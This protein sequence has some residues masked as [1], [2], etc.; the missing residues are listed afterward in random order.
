MN[1]G[2]DAPREA[3]VQGRTA[4]PTMGGRRGLEVRCD[5]LEACRWLQMLEP[6][7]RLRR[8]TT[9]NLNAKTA[10]TAKGGILP[11]G[12]QKRLMFFVSAIRCNLVQSTATGRSDFLNRQ[13]SKEPDRV[14]EEN[15]INA[16]TAK[17]AKR[18]RRS[19]D[20]NVR[21]AAP[22]PTEVVG[23]YR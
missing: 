16:K 2:G 1:T 9:T 20:R 14:E 22:Y 6:Q 11:R 23:V 3:A 17:G 15:D 10:K 8:R 7:E 19:R 12:W 18:K 4:L 5:V 13:R 21:I